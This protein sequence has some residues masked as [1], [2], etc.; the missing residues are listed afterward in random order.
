MRWVNKQRV[1]ECLEDLNNKE[2]QE[3]LWLSTGKGGSDVSSFEE[4]YCQLYDDCGLWDALEK[5]PVYGDSIDKQ[6]LFLEVQMKNVDAYRYPSE[7]INSPEMQ[8][9]RKLATKILVEIEDAEKKI[10][11]LYRTKVIWERCESVGEY[12]AQVDGEVCLLGLNNS[13]DEP[14]CTITYKGQKIDFVEFG[15]KWEIPWR[16]NGD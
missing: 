12:K 14:I 3:K 10:E 11:G 8:R 2:L 4:T 13:P 6:L 9:I 15:E 7:I 1:R 16:F 5:E